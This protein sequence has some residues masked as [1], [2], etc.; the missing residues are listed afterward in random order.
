MDLPLIRNGGLGYT[1]YDFFLRPYTAFFLSH[2]CPFFLN[3]RISLTFCDGRV[4]EIR[5][6][7]VLLRGDTNA[8]ML[9][10][11]RATHVQS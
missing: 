10:L 1:L 7:V 11:K 9:S 3:L 5:T 8:R 2:P 6:C 4:N